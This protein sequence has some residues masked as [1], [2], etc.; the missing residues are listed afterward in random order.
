[1]RKIK[2]ALSLLPAM[3]LWLMASVF[4]W[5]FVFVQITDTGREHKLVL[6]VDGAVPDET[7]LSV[8]LE[9]GAGEGIRMVQARAFSYAMFDET[10]LVNAD[11]YIVPAS[12]AETYA[13]WFAPL[14]P[15]APEAKDVLTLAGGAQG[16]KIYDAGAGEGAAAS[17]I[18]YASPGA[19]AEDY[20]LFFGKASL[21]AAGRENAVDCAAAAA[22]RRL[23]DLP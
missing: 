15:D 18:L 13:D 20:Y 16:L 4:V 7:A 3:I 19:E 6:F 1:M 22:A 10:A 2:K 5:G 8:K 23:L 11:L 9:E 21:H 17:L 14:P 12:R